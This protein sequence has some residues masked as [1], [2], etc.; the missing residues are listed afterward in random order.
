MKKNFIDL[1]G[2]LFIALFMFCVLYNAN[3]QSSQTQNLNDVTSYF[4]RANGNDNNSGTTEDKPLKTLA[5]A[6]E[7]AS[8]S[9]VKKI[10]VIGTLVGA[11]VIDNSGTDEIL[12]TGKVNASNIEK[13][14]LT[15]LTK[16]TYT[17]RITGNSKIKLE[18][19]TGNTAHLTPAKN[20]EGSPLDVDFL[21]NKSG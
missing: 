4:V 14:V 7:V 18:Y 16:D 6:V 11:T 20:S 15:T 8:K 2:T 3:S 19:L 17:I 13:A 9:K 21:P 1:T 12:I 5:K 10:T